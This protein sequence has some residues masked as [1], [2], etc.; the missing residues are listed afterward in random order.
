MKSTGIVR[1]IDNMGRVVLPKEL[2]R[3]MHFREDEPLE[4]YVEGDT[5]ILKRYKESCIIC[6]EQ[7]QTVL[8]EVK[9]K[10]VC[11]HCLE[12]GQEELKNDYIK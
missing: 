10:K 8:V 2:R 6:G 1:R 3:T 4:I 9:N 5:I 12:A 7:E 11:K